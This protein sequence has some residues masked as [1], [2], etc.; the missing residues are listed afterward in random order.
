MF[1]PNR[2]FLQL[3]AWGLGVIAV[4][5]AFAQQP[6]PLNDL[7]AFTN[8]AGNWKI[9]GDASVDIS[10]EN[11]LNTKPGKG[12]LACIHEKGKYGQEYELDIEFQA[13]RSG[14]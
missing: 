6:I 1:K 11:V 9:V 14:Y 7:S 12:V 8:K 3:F 2:F 5:S 4:Q 13:R 10:K